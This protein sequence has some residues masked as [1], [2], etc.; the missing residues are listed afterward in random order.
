M[1]VTLRKSESLNADSLAS[2]KE[3]TDA[4]PALRINF[5]KNS[6]ENPSIFSIFVRYIDKN[7]IYGF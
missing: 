6:K 5:S 4:N 3:N 2:Q 1:P 7:I